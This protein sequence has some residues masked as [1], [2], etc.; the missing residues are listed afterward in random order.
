MITALWATKVEYFL[1]S[2]IPVTSHIILWWYE[3]DGF[4]YEKTTAAK[5]MQTKQD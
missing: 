5:E 3:Y 4:E 2:S 1:I